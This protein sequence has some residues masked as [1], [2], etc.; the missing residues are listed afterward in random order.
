MYHSQSIEPDKSSNVANEFRAVGFIFVLFSSHIHSRHH[1]LKIYN[2]QIDTSTI[3]AI[4]ATYET[5]M[6]RNTLPIRVVLSK[7]NIVFSVIE[8]C[9][10]C[11]SYIVLSPHP[12]LN[13]LLLVFKIIGYQNEIHQRGQQMLCSVT[14]EICFMLN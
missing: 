10:Y 1:L 6:K 3:G 13:S 7:A 9:S 4:V 14:K 2:F 12:T 8:K 11:E 5:K